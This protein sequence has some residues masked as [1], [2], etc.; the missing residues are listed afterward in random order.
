MARGFGASGHTYNRQCECRQCAAARRPLWTRTTAAIIEPTLGVLDCFPREVRD[1]MYG[2]CILASTNVAVRHSPNSN[3]TPTPA[4]T[5]EPVVVRLT[6][7]GLTSKII[8]REVLAEAKRQ[9]KH[10][11]FHEIPLQY[12]LAIHHLTTN[13]VPPPTMSDWPCAKHILVKVTLCNSIPV[14]YDFTGY[15]SPWLYPITSHFCPRLLQSFPHLKSVV[16]DMPTPGCRKLLLQ[17]A[18][19]ML[20]DDRRFVSVATLRG[21]QMLIAYRTKLGGIEIRPE[22]FLTSAQ[23]QRWL[24]PELVAREG[25]DWV[26]AAAILRS[27]RY[28]RS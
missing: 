22:A 19:H 17:E 20:I 21:S 26:E 27:G 3:I 13:P 23:M 12:D 14:P 25:E 11:E 10:I 18:I 15:V 16:F 9:I 7:L 28:L 2:Y 6:K 4:T 1:K 24:D 5:T 8:H